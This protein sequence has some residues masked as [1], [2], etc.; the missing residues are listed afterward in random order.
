MILRSSYSLQH[1]TRFLTMML[2]LCDHLAKNN[3][4]VVPYTDQSAT[5]FDSL[6]TNLKQSKI[7]AL[8]RYIKV[9]ET[10]TH[11]RVN[12]KSARDLVAKTLFSNSWIGANG[13]L[14]N[15]DD[16]CLIEMYDHNQVKVFSNFRFYELCSYDLTTCWTYSWNELFDRPEGVESELLGYTRQAFNLRPRDVLKIDT[17]IHYIK[18]RFSKHQRLFSYRADFISPVYSKNSRGIKDL[19]GVIVVSQAE[20]IKEK[21]MQPSKPKLELARSRDPREE[22]NG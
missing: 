10:T 7:D 13:L 16:S 20:L 15:I 21:S 9:L 8:E 1:T 18:E 2:D 3:I 22:V 14:E 17:P 11:Q 12:L 5:D 4:E 19:E 6:D